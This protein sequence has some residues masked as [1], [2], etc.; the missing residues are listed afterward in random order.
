MSGVLR[1]SGISK[2]SSSKNALQRRQQKILEILK[3]RGKAQVGD[4]KKIFPS[5]SKRTLRRDFRGL[6]DNGLVE[7]IGEK[8]DTFYQFLGRTDG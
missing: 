2:R 6:T 7:R 4:F 8:N 3:E 1:S 5:V